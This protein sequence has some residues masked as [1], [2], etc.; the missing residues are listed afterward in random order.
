MSEFLDQQYQ[1]GGPFALPGGPLVLADALLVLPTVEAATL[2]LWDPQAGSP[3]SHLVISQDGT[4]VLDALAPTSQADGL[5]QVLTYVD[6]TRNTTA[7]LIVMASRLPTALTQTNRVF[8]ERTVVRRLDKVTSLNGLSGDVVL[9]FPDYTNA[10]IVG[11]QV[12]LNMQNPVDRVECP[13][14]PCEAKIYQINQQVADA[15]GQLA[16]RSDG[17]FRFVPD[18]AVPGRLKWFDMCTPCF[19]CDAVQAI[20]DVITARA[21]YGYQLG[22]I[23]NS[24][25]SRYQRA[26]T[27]VNTKFCEQLAGAT[28]TLPTGGIYVTGRTIE[29]PYFNQLI[30]ALANDSREDVEITLTGT[31]MA[32]NGV[33][34]TVAAFIQQNIGDGEYIDTWSGFPGTLVLTIPAQ[35]LVTVECEVK[36]ATMDFPGPASGSWSITG[37]IVAASGTYP[38]NLAFPFNIPIVPPTLLPAPPP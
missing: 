19:A 12:T 17:C 31:V 37:S 1:V 38:V 23:F 18:P 3:A 8:A 15:D 22:A 11:S 25:H 10:V 36:R 7:R 35:S 32:V 21:E 2:D 4:V 29:R 9:N 26:V 34:A 27:K 13:E 6:T 28:A 20:G 33:L 5:W 30:L 14:N 24:Q 16:L